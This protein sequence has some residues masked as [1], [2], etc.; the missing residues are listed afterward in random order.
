MIMT[1]LI[2]SVEEEKLDFF[3]Q[4]MDSLDFVQFE[5]YKPYDLSKEQIHMLNER[6]E[7]YKSNPD[8]SKDWESIKQELD[9]EFG[10]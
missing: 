7:E 1:K 3:M 6:L 9:N 5:K 4:L 2:I 8:S 10:I